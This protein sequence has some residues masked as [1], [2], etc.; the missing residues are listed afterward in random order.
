M[1]S[2]KAADCTMAASDSYWKSFKDIGNSVGGG[3][4]C[5]AVACTLRTRREF[6]L[7]RERQTLILIPVAEANNIRTFIAD[8][9]LRS[10]HAA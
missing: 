9:R 10:A 5:Y 8:N 3:A 4:R 2:F 1:Q 6:T 7:S